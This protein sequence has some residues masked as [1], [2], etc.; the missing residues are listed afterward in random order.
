VKAD[1]A[2]L[3]KELQKKALGYF[4]EVGLPIPT[5]TASKAQSAKPPRTEGTV[6]EAAK[7]SIIKMI[8][9]KKDVEIRKPEKEAIALEATCSVADVEQTLKSEFVGFPIGEKGRKSKYG[10]KR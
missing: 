5:Q 10:L 2:A 1:L 3:E 4:R 6:N 9:K 7:A 8:G